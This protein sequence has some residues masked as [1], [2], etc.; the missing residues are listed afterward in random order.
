ME[1][2]ATLPTLVILPSET[3]TL[4]KVP[5]AAELAPIVVPSILPPSISAVVTVPKSAIVVPLKVEFFPTTI[6][7]LL[8]VVT[9]LR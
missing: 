8:F 1:S 2:H 4:V 3:L 7:S 9:N 6:C 5:A